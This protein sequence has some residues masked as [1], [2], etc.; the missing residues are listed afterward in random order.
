MKKIVMALLI[1]FISLFVATAKDISV[2]VVQNAANP[3]SK[4]DPDLVTP[5]VVYEKLKDGNVNCIYKFDLD[6]EKDID[7]YFVNMK[8][9]LPAGVKYF[10]TAF[11]GIAAFEIDGEQV[12]ALLEYETYMDCLIPVKKKGSG[13]VEIQ[14]TIPKSYIGKDVPIKVTFDGYKRKKMKLVYENSG[15]TIVGCFFALPGF[16]VGAI[17]D[18]YQISKATKEYTMNFK[19]AQVEEKFSIIKDEGNYKKISMANSMKKFLLQVR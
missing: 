10:V 6:A 1:S 9:N 12:P 8:I 15:A 5:W 17:Y 3:G 14:V 2:N 19:Q 4:Y 11:D 7:D 13:F 16:L 18:G